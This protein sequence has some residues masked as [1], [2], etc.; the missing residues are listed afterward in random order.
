MIQTSDIKTVNCSPLELNSKETDLIAHY[1]QNTWQLDRSQTVKKSDTTL[2]KTAEMAVFKYIKKNLN[3]LQY[4]P[5]DYFRVDNCKK[6]AP[7]DGL[8]FKKDI[9]NNIL[10][11][12]IDKINQQVSLVKHGQIDALLKQECLHHHIYTVEI[13]STR[14]TSRHYNSNILNLNKILNDDFLEYPKYTRTDPYNIIHN[15]DDYIRFIHQSTG[16]HQSKE[17]ILL[18]EKRNMK[19][20]Y[21]RVYIDESQSIAYIIGCISYKTFIQKGMIKRMPQT[22]K[23][24]YAVYWAC[25]LH[26]GES[27]DILQQLS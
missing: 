13:K 6:H 11:N 18:E 20:I 12:I 24:E 14:I 3:Q 2:G 4:L 26:N 21:I 23:S 25:P 10:K 5:Y 9:N 27:I 8:I 22:N 7:F 17:D 15:L 16:L 19:H 1:T